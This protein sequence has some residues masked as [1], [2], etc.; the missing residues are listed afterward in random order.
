MNDSMAFRERTSAA[1]SGHFHGHSATAMRAD[2]RYIHES[3]GTPDA[4]WLASHYPFET[5]AARDRALSEFW[6]APTLTSPA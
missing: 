4:A 5:Q 6:A 1:D 2:L 3:G